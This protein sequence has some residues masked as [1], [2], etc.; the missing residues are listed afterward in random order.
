MKIKV[1][2]IKI[3]INTPLLGQKKGSIVTLAT[4]RSGKVINAFWAARIKDAEIDDCV[5]IITALDSSMTD[6]T[7]NKKGKKS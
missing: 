4:D 7:T 6:K 1:K 2:T 5:S 3:L